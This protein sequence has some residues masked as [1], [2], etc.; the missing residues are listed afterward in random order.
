MNLERLSPCT[1]CGMAP[2]AWQGEVRQAIRSIPLTC[3]QADACQRGTMPAVRLASRGDD[4][5]FSASVWR[6]SPPCSPYRGS[7]RILATTISGTDILGCVGNIG[8]TTRSY[9]LPLCTDSARGALH[10]HG[11]AMSPDSS[12]GLFA[13][14]ELSFLTASSLGLTFSRAEREIA[15]IRWP[16]VLGRGGGSL[17]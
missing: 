2:L 10:N 11:Y 7:P 3:L 9:R 5:S 12:S 17:F 1:N 4:G 6:W 14:S 16:N 13:H 15:V 8:D